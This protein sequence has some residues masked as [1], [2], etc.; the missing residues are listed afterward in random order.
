MV[1]RLFL[2]VPRGCLQFVIV[3]FPD[4]THYFSGLRVHHQWFHFF[5]KKTARALAKK[6][7]LTEFSPEQ[8][9]EKQVNFTDL[10]P[11]VSSTNFAQ[12]VP[13]H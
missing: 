4:H 11:M 1:E 8:L 5:E 9:A 13:L 6:L 12:T 3:V 2:A 7:L 10:Y